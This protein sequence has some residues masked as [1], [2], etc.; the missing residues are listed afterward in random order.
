MNFLEK[1]A[2]EALKTTYMLKNETL[3]PS[4]I[5]IPNVGT[6]DENGAK[7]VKDIFSTLHDARIIMC[8]GEVN[9]TMASVVVGQLLHLS[10]EDEKAPIH[11]YINSP[12]GSITAGRAIFDAM[13][14][15]K[16][17]VITI[18]L[19]MCASMGS[20]LLAAGNLTGGAKILPGTE[21]MI[22]QRATRLCA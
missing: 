12:G 14:Y 21:V 18:G 6:T 9:D 5:V 3:N 17:P 11:M 13:L 8:D 19:G 22:H 15:I 10:Y 20:F 2:L 1:N 4:N 16:C 7:T